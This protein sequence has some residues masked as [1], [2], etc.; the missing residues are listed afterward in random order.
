[1]KKHLFPLLLTGALMLS[2]FSACSAQTDT[3]SSAS[4][5]ETISA[6][7]VT[8]ADS[9]DYTRTGSASAV[10]TLSG[11]SA[12]ADGSGVSISGSV[13]TITSGGTFT[14]SG[15]L[16]DGQIIVDAKGEDVVLTLN[17]ADITCSWSSPLYIYKSESTTVTLADGTKN[18]LT[19]AAAYTYS[20]TYSS[21]ADEEPNACLYSKSDLVINGSGTLTVNAN[22]KN[23]I[24]SKDTLK[25]TA[26]TLVVNAVNHGINGKDCCVVSG[27]DLTVVS[28]GDALRSTNDTDATLG[29][30]G[31]S[32]S[33]LNL[34]SGEDGIQ[35]E[36][37][38]SIESGTFTIT[39]GGGSSQ[40][41]SDDTSTKGI[42]AG[43]DLEISGGT[44]TIDSSDDAVHCNGSLTVSGGTFTV[45]SGD[46]GFHSDETLTI[47][48]GA[49]SVA[50]SYEGI[51]GT[52]IVISGGEIQVVSSD[53]GLNAAGGADSSGFG[54][55]G[56]ANQFAA[57]DGT[58][59]TITISGGSI[60]VNAGGDGVDS[61]G[62]ITMTDGTL[63]VFGPTDDS[64]GSLDYN[65]TFT[66]S[67]GTLLAAGSSGMAQSPSDLSEYAVS[68]TADSTLTAGTVVEISWGSGSFVFEIQKD[69]K[70]IVFACPDIQSGDTVTVTAGGTYSGA[71]A[72]GVGSGGACSGGTEIAS[73]S[74]SDYLTSYGQ[75]GVGG[76]MGGGTFGNPGG[77][78]SGAPGGM[79]RP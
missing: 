57:S 17:G 8:F 71:F 6:E 60:Y 37:S 19:D 40:S 74:V 51:E 55:F 76:S 9:D 54:G 13:V 65:N 29:W 24:T 35:A 77:S 14:V 42:K 18:S 67:G 30:I 45:S 27:A 47:S 59:S 33:T 1:M 48:G 22:F 53:D 78:M 69:T 66:L 50:K 23:G 46:D 56:S 16:N 11:D 28:G 20:D 58:E 79:G 7:D 44:F 2:L 25:I 75:V 43:T 36:T 68:V 5:G 52:A 73:L 38:L 3:A 61:N 63:I 21:A 39:A 4:S 41:P 32:D 15:T 62:S 12:S 72:N 26:A 31:I 10:I 34:T 70:N 64:N 49:I